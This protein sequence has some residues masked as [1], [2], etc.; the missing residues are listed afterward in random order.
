MDWTLQ[1]TVCAVN[2]SKVGVKTVRTDQA[3][4]A[5]ESLTCCQAN[6]TRVGVKAVRTDPAAPPMKSLTNCQAKGDK[7]E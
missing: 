3:A 5:M 6:R 2:K 4:T 1:L 7:S